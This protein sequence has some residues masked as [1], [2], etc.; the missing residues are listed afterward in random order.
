MHRARP[1]LVSA[2]AVG[3]LLAGC[4]GDDEPTSS[5]DTTRATSTTAADDP[6]TSDDEPATETE[7]EA[8]ETEATEDE[9]VSTGGGEA[10]AFCA[11]N[12]SMEDL[13]DGL[14]GSTLEGVQ[15]GA[16]D[17]VEAAEALDDDVPEEIADDVDALIEGFGQLKEATDDAVTLEAAQAEARA[18]SEALDLDAAGERVSDWV[19]SNC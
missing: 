14:D 1:L 2:V 7:T 16:A 5:S 13:I 17:I 11:A 8:T 15:S 4:G 9:P 10:E 3:A 12:Q 19:D 6:T 18:V